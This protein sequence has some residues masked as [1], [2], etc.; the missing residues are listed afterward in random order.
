VDDWPI[1][2]P[3]SEVEFDLF[4]GHFSDLLD[5]VFGSKR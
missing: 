4:E 5:E 3:V 2:I 1:S